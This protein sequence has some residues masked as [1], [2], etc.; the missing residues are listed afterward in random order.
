MVTSKNVVPAKAGI[1]TSS[2]RKSGTIL[3]T[4]SRFSS[5]ILDSCFHRSDELGIIRGSLIF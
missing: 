2:R 5:G 4:G 1:Q 3:D